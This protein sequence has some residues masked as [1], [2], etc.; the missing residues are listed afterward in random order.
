MGVMIEM[1]FGRGSDDFTA[2]KGRKI[3]DAKLT[4][5][6]L[7]LSFEGTEE[8]LRVYDAGQSCCENRY[9]TS[10]DDVKDLVGGNL[11][12]IEEREGPEPEPAVCDKC[13]G[14][15]RLDFSDQPM[16]DPEGGEEC[17]ACHGT[18]NDYYSG[19]H[20]VAFVLI[21]T[22]NDS[23]TLCTHN[24]HNGWY[25]GFALKVEVLNK[26]PD[27]APGTDGFNSFSV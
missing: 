18:G 8:Q 26:K 21:Q 15:K 27:G 3:T 22:D 6:D 19:D 25:G 7:T 4:T 14:S 23:I 5:D 13:K 1:L 10:D 11:V 20:E 24:E 16:L 9:I 2:F 17:W 12:S